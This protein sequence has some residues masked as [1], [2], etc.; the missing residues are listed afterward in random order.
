MLEQVYLY[1]LAL[2]NVQLEGHRPSELLRHMQQL[3][4][5]AASPLSE[6]VL[7][8]RHAKLL[9]PPMQLYLQPLQHLPLH[10]LHPSMQHSNNTTALHLV[11]FHPPLQQQLTTTPHIQLC[12]NHQ[13]MAPTLVIADHPAS[14]WSL[15]TARRPSPCREM[16]EAV[17]RVRP[18]RYCP[19]H[20]TPLGA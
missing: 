20:Y 6:A 15:P 8:S 19:H 10:T 2:D 17:A 16:N 12:N 9:S 5:K 7:R 14:V 13:R 18:P 11:S 3:H 4:E 1:L